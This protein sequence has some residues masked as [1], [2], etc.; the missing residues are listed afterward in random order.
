VSAR[1]F[2]ASLDRWIVETLARKSST[3]FF[4]VALLF[5]CTRSDEKK[6][7]T[8]RSGTSEAKARVDET[9]ATRVTDPSA[10]EG[11]GGQ[12]TLVNLEAIV[13]PQCY[14]RTEGK[15]NPCYVCHQ[16]PI[17]GDGHENRMADGV[18]QGEYSFSDFALENRWRNL[19][20]DRTQQVAAI[21]DEAI[22]AYV[23]SDNYTPLYEQ[24]RERQGFAGY[25]PDL[26]DLHLGASAFDKNGFA[27]DE[28]RW[29]AFNYMPMPSTFWPTNGATDD[30]MIRLPREFRQLTSDGPYVHE[31]YV[32]NLA[33]LEAAI[34]NIDN[35]GCLPL[36]ERKVQVDLDGDGK[37]SQTRR[38]RRPTHYVG[39]ASSVEVHT[40]LYPRGTEFLHTVR[41]LGVDKQ[42]GIQIPPRM[43]E[44]RYM[45]KRSFIP[46][47]A[48]AGLYDNE[49]QE[50]IEASPPYYADFRELGVDNGYGWLVQGY[51]EDAAGNLRSNSYEETLFCMGCHSTIGSTIDHVFAFGRKVDGQ[52]GWGYINLRGMPDAPSW[53]EQEGQIRAYLRR[54]G[55]GSEFRNNDEMQAR[56]FRA[57]GTLDEA[58]VSAAKDVYALITPS[59]ERART[60]NKAYRVL[61]GEQSFL[62]GRDPT[63]TPP[64]NVYHQV[65][66]ETPP[67]AADRHF[68]WDIRVAW[69]DY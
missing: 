65:D 50:K 37:L 15:H 19:F 32:A 55:G 44:L 6:P 48:V 61:V 26:K 68:R 36:D 54:V 67:L 17:E 40:F 3:L 49:K 46:K 33:I 13:P 66:A 47:F 28:S 21:T 10:E 1:C 35:M 14:T 64:K 62:Y 7:I 20:V 31:V 8:T 24:M 57:D 27:R 2:S 22:D 9:L 63:I 38:I 18:L 30:V 34:K 52:A 43:K 16:S 42:G 53:G 69:R 60:L 29:V 58:K 41:Y 56:Y 39:A 12:G 23:A 11:P 25:K 5:G 45:R 59:P 51:I 4:A